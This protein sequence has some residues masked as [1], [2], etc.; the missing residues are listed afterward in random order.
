MQKI[1]NIL[2]L[3]PLKLLYKLLYINYNIVVSSIDIAGMGLFLCI[4]ASL[5]TD[6]AWQIMVNLLHAVVFPL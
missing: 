6:A 3:Y 5:A 1:D 2:Q 4:M